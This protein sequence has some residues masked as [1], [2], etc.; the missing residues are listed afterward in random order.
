MDALSGIRTH[1]PSVR[2]MHALSGIRTHDPSV[3]A[4]EDSSRHCDRPDM[5]RGVNYSSI[6]T[7]KYVSHRRVLEIKMYVITCY[8]DAP[9]SDDCFF[10][11]K[12]WT[13]D[14]LI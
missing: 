11:G 6:C 1:D 2:D 3:R 8:A 4:S 14:T 5:R 9:G 13:N 10:A 12:E 7:I